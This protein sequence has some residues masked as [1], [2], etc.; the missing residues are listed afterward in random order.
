MYVLYMVLSSQEGLGCSLEK[1]Y[2]AGGKK[3][4]KDKNVSYV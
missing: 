3:D 1:S 2:A 4:A